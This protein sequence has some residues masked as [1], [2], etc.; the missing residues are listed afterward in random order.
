VTI[1]DTSSAG[2]AVRRDGA[3]ATV[4]LG[5]DDGWRGALDTSAKQSLRANLERLATDVSV[6]A[7]VLTGRGSAFCTG[8]DLREHAVALDAD[9]TAAFDSVRQHYGP[10]ALMLATM[11]KPVVAAVNGA[12]AGAGAAFAFACDLRLMADTA[13]FHLAFGR[14]GLSVDTGMSWT[15]PRLVG[16]GRALDLLLRPRQIDASAA[17]ELGLAQEVVASE[18]LA[19]RAADV[20]AELAD[21]PT[22]AFGAT[23]QALAYAA[24]NTLAD[25]LEMEAALQ[26]VAGTTQDHVD[27]VQAFLAK[28][29]PR[30]SGR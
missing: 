8:Q 20:A 26:T 23:K 5:P 12:A 15:L 19:A 16:T 17:L 29:S 10:V 25:A 30:F 22:I 14:I 24:G 13:S 6:R 1:R 2:V 11:A 21:G 28:Q 4:V 27:A 3:V 18:A 7:V 9:A